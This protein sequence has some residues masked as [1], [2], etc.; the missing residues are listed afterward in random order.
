MICGSA[1]GLQDESITVCQKY[2]ASKDDDL[3]DSGDNKDSEDLF[4]TM[5]DYRES[6]KLSSYESHR[7]L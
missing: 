7:H 2:G 6:G 3:G 1:P 4:L 5:N